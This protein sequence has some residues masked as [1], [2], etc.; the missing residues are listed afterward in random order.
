[1]SST[2]RL[3]HKPASARKT[4]DNTPGLN[5]WKRIGDFGS[6]VIYASGDLRHLVDPNTGR[7]IAQYKFNHAGEDETNAG[8]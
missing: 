6:Y 8:L 1:M 4:G 3:T 5:G 7:I 2:E